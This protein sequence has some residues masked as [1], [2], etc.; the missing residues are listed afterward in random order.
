MSV[1]DFI[2]SCVKMPSVSKVEIPIFF[3]SE[4]YGGTATNDDSLEDIKIRI[5]SINNRKEV[6]GYNKNEAL[7]LIYEN[8]KWILYRV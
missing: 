4:K 6:Y 3:L 2:E 1:S 7:V 5:C 8:D